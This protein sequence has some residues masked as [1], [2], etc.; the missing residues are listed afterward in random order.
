MGCYSQVNPDLID[1]NI[2]LGNKDKSK[3]I[4]LLDECIKKKEKIGTIAI[5]TSSEVN[6]NTW[7]IEFSAEIVF[8]IIEKS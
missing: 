4:E 7:K 2:V 8:F 6:F 1:A 3:I 5:K